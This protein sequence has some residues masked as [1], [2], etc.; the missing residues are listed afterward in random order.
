MEELKMTAL[1]LASGDA[2]IA[3]VGREL[4]RNLL[5]ITPRLKYLNLM[6]SQYILT[7]MFLPFDTFGPMKYDVCLDI[8]TPDI[9]HVIFSAYLQQEIS[10]WKIF[11]AN[12][13]P[14]YL[15]TLMHTYSCLYA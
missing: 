2:K 9:F 5:G 15:Q 14:T 12:M 7:T 8:S 11:L 3:V 6:S 13:F 10:V 4:C 1:I